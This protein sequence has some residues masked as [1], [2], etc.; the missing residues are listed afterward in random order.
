MQRWFFASPSSFTPHSYN[1]LITFFYG[2]APGVEEG[3][4]LIPAVLLRNPF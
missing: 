3:S 1:L 4:Y 2:A